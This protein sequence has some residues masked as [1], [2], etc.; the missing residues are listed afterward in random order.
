MKKTFVSA[1]VAALAGALAASGAGA[2][3]IAIYPE[4]EVYQEAG[5]QGGV[6]IGYLDCGIAGGVGYVLGSASG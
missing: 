2:A 3:D 4:A 6:R 5:P 1:C